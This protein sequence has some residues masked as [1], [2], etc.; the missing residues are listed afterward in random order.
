MCLTSDQLRH[1]FSHCWMLV[2]RFAMTLM[3]FQLW[4][5]KR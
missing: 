1:H 2:Y 5:A 4:R 3:A